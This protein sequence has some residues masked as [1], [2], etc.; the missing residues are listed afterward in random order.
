[1]SKVAFITGA[2]TGMGRGVATSLAKQGYKVVIADWNHHDGQQLVDEIKADFRKVDVTS[3]AD[4]FNAFDE[5][6][7]KYGRIDFGM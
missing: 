5:T 2:A 1:M 4:Q 7:K 6:F 3:W